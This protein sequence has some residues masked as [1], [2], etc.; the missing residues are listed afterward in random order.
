MQR[1]L[2]QGREERKW[3]HRDDAAWKGGE[4][5]FISDSFLIP[6]SHETQLGCLPLCSEK[7]HLL[8]ISSSFRLSHFE[9]VLVL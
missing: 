1:Q 3:M 5:A 9:Q 8:P 2:A 6:S 4:G 7:S